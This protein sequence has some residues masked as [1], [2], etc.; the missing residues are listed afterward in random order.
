MSPALA[1][2]FGTASRRSG[3][4]MGPSRSRRRRAAPGFWAA[5][6]GAP[7]CGM[8]GGCALGG[9]GRSI[10]VTGPICCLLQSPSGGEVDAADTTYGLL[11]PQTGRVQRLGETP[12][13]VT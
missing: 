5:V 12:D 9:C 11:P 6:D 13:R 1:T 7:A 4:T 10:T 3:E 2:T 8:L